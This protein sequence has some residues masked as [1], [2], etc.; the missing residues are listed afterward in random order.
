MPKFNNPAG[1][2]EEVS[3]EAPLPARVPKKKKKSGAAPSTRTIVEE[4]LEVRQ[5]VRTSIYV[6]KILLLQKNFPNELE[7]DYS[8]E[9][10]AEMDTD[11]LKVLFNELLRDVNIMGEGNYLESSLRAIGTLVDKTDAYGCGGWGE[12]D[13]NP[14]L[15]GDENFRT[16]L[17][18]LN[19]QYLDK[20]SIFASPQLQV[21]S[22][23]ASSLY[24]RRDLNQKLQKRSAEAVQGKSFAERMKD[25]EVPESEVSMSSDEEVY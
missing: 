21:A 15:D 24:N 10:L 23:L 17:M 2:E 9:E 5:E 25:Q 7:T 8:R 13:L 3:L 11:D 14:L 19:I 16:Q 18:L 20:I 12:K 1:S 22:Y 6:Q 4:Q